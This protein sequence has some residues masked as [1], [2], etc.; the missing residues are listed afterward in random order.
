MADRIYSELRGMIETAEN[1]HNQVDE[2]RKHHKS[3]NERLKKLLKEARAELTTT[4]PCII[5][6]SEAKIGE[7]VA[8]TNFHDPDEWIVERVQKPFGVVYD[9]IV[10]RLPEA[11]KGYAPDDH[12]DA[13]ITQWH[14]PTEGDSSDGAIQKLEEAAV[15]TEARHGSS[16]EDAMPFVKLEDGTWSSY[17]K[18][19]NGLTAGRLVDAN[20]TVLTPPA[21][22]G[23]KIDPTSLRPGDIFDAYFDGNNLRAGDKLEGSTVDKVEDDI[24]HTAS[25]NAMEGFWVTDERT[26]GAVVPEVYLVER[27]KRKGESIS[28]DSIRVGDRI[29]IYGYALIPDGEEFTVTHKDAHSIR[30]H[31]REFMVKPFGYGDHELRLVERPDKALPTKAGSVVIANEFMGEKLEAPITAMLDDLGEW[32]ASSEWPN[33][34]VCTLPVNI[35]GFTPV[36][37][38]VQPALESANA[39]A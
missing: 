24:C 27:A 5:E 28:R 32:A 38:L 1:N 39:F 25:G 16:P 19:G 13:E 6:P 11:T 2:A 34:H 33:G 14:E 29:A 35:T 18:D 17:L 37:L 8:F 10:I 30:G 15:G 22:R 7:L 23:E 4:P 36:Q 21:R 20:F 12:E 3:E 26:P 31:E 9:G